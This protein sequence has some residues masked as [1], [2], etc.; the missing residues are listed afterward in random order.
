MSALLTPSCCTNALL[1]RSLSLA[2]GAAD[3]TKFIEIPIFDVPE[4]VGPGVPVG[5][6]VGDGNGWSV[7]VPVG[8][9]DGRS[10]GSAVGSSVGTAVGSNDG[11]SVGPAEGAG[12]G[13]SVGCAEGGITG[14]FTPM[15][16][17]VA[18]KPL[19]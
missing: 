4:V 14:A 9:N 8:G 12:L 5:L 16:L 18:K 19:K 15:W 11:R 1:S 17:M 6:N 10:V 13:S 3:A 2:V 7:G